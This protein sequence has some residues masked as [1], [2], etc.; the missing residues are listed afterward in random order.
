MSKRFGLV[1]LP[2]RY[3]SAASYLNNLWRHLTRAPDCC[4]LLTGESRTCRVW[5]SISKALVLLARPWTHM[6]SV[7]SGQRWPPWSTSSGWTVVD[8]TV[9]SVEITS[10][11]NIVLV[12]TSDNAESSWPAI[13]STVFR[14]SWKG[15]VKVVSSIQLWGFLF[16]FYSDFPTV[17]SLY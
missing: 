7:N 14:T 5:T 16:N 4:Q 12:M 1:K 10:S 9:N 13:F 3:S 17:N 6:P 8:R 11:Q 2:A 15:R